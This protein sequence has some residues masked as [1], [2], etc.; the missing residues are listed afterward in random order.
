MNQQIISSHVI[1]NLVIDTIANQQALISLQKFNKGDI[2]HSFSAKE[3]LETPNYL[4]LQIAA[5]KH[6]LLQPSF[7]QYTN[8]SCQPNVFF[9]TT[10]LQLKALQDIEIGTELTFFYPSTEWKMQQPF[11]CFCGHNNCIGRIEGAENLP[12]HLLPNYKFSLFIQ[13]MLAQ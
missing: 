11:T 10:T 13:Q 4:T 2:L 5:N 12:K 9:N 3:I 7:L 8:H 1:A 6:I